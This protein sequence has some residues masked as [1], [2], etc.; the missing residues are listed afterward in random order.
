M[1]I[2]WMENALCEYHTYTSLALPVHSGAGASTATVISAENNA[3]ISGIEGIP[4]AR[5]RTQTAFLETRSK[6]EEE[7]VT[8]WKGFQTNEGEILPGIARSE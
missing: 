4:G 5:H 2:G 6:R 1:S 7:R 3:E 8:P